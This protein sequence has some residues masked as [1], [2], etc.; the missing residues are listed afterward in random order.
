MEFS[1]EISIGV[2]SHYL[3]ASSAVMAIV[4]NESGIHF[5]DDKEDGFK[6]REGVQVFKTE[7][8]YRHHKGTAVTKD[9]SY[10][11]LS[12]LHEGARKNLL[13]VYDEEKRRY[14]VKARLN[15]NEVVVEMAD[16]S[17][18]GKYLAAGGSDG[19]VCVY[20]V[21]DGKFITI[22]PR[23][24]EYITALDFGPDSRMIGYASFKKNLTI[25]DMTRSMPIGF[26]G[27]GEIITCL[28]FLHGTKFLVFGARDNKIYLYDILNGRILRELCETVNWPVA[29][30]IDPDD[31]FCLVSDKVG[32][33]YLSDLTSEEV[34]AQPMYKSDHVI[35]DMHYR[36]DEYFFLFENGKMATLNVTKERDKLLTSIEEQDIKLSRRTRCSNSGVR[37]SW[38]NWIPPITT[39]LIWRWLRL[40]KETRRKPAR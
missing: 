10:L 1:R 33:L 32:Y 9:G 2:D 38:K 28:K 36:G 31:R 3:I 30:H 13:F 25:Y 29:I 26:Y 22:L 20:S 34:T 18:D 40:P 16:F 19:K 8:P 24:S 21:S 15:W 27:H 7:V 4:D 6:E 39:N 14:R 35:V 17:P 23:Q 37:P 5:L 11:C 12:V